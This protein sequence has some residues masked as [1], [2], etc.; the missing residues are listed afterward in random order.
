MQKFAQSLARFEIWI[1]GGCVAASFV[2]LRALPFAVASAFLFGLV[3]WAGTGRVSRP[4]PGDGP[5]LILLLMVPVTLWVTAELEVTI[6]QVLRLLAGIGIYYAVINWTITPDRMHWL[7][8]GVW[9]AGL[10]IA[11]YAFISVQWNSA[12]LFFIP[13]ALYSHFKILVSDTSNPNA[14]AAGLVILLPCA[15][16]VLFFYGRRLGR[17]DQGLAFLSA[18]LMILVLVLTQSRGGLLAFLAVILLLVVLRWKR[19][20]W[21]LVGATTLSVLL[22][23]I[24]G[25]TA[26][27]N[28]IVANVTLGG[29]DGRIEVWSRAIY[30]VQDFPFTGVGIG[31]YGPV[32]DLLYPFFLYAPGT[33]PHAHNLFVQIAVDLGIPGLIAWLATWM[34]VIATARMI[35][36]RGK[37]MDDGWASGLG[38]GLLCSQLA[39]GLHGMVD[40]A[41]WGITKSAPLVWLLW[42]VT[43]AGWYVYARR[44]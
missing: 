39:L 41:I 42:G 24:M 7:V 35:Y 25:P 12:K 34:L 1:V 11:L 3:R 40:A 31:S 26:V 10:L 29:M 44:S 36:L 38:A 32:A 17:L 16:G 6:P 15:L 43:V 8:R 4:T 2:T 14:M 13:A 21:L 37:S 20:W 9:L 33:A 30:M 27:L 18:G 22:F 19:G 23:M 28:E 5:V